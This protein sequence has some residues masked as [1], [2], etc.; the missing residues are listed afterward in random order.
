MLRGKPSVLSLP[1]LLFVSSDRQLVEI[2]PVVDSEG[3]AYQACHIALPS[4]RRLVRTLF[5]VQSC[6]AGAQL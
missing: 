3:V 4:R 6:L 2:V 1:D 5:E